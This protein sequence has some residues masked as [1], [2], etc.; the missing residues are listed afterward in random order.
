MLGIAA[1]G[2]T[3]VGGIAALRLSRHLWLLFSVAA[4]IVLGVAIFE[5]YPE[6]IAL[7]GTAH[8]VRP[9]SVALAIGFG[10]YLLVDQVLGDVR[11]GATRWRHHVAPAMLTLHSL[12]DGLG[13]GL[14]FQLD[15]R[16]GSLIAV[17]VLAHDV[18]DGINTVGLS[19]AGRD[20]TSA[21]LWLGINSAAPI[22]GVLLGQRLL[23]SSNTLAM[24]LAA[25]AGI[26]IYI[27]GCELLPRSRALDPRGLSAVASLAGLA[28]MAV[29]TGLMA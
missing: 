26:F 16:T 10:A 28:F 19:L 23:V 11:A 2:A 22:V 7:G 13:I 4:G 3:L 15:S 21:R 14:A 20:R 9:L 17:A 5:L 12:V 8:G 25:F 27:G 1:A 6:A 24:L 18:A 29:V